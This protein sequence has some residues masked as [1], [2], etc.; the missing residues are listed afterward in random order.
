VDRPES[1]ERAPTAANVM[2]WRSAGGFR[3]TCQTC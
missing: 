2:A 3:R 1:T